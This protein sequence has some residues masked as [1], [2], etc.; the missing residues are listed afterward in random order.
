[1]PHLS[2]PEEALKWAE[3]AEKKY[4]P[5]LLVLG[6]FVA[7]FSRVEID[8]QKV[9]WKFAGVQAPT[10]QA[11]FSGVRVDGAMQFITRIADAQNW[12]DTK[13]DELEYV[14]SQPRA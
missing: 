14:F 11:L 13:K 5:Y 12:D 8:L 10:A 9:L 3:A 7:L 4:Q 6:R 2:T 1:M